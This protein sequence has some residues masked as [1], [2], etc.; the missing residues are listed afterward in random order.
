MS[1]EKTSRDAIEHTARDLRDT[2]VKNGKPDPG[3]DKAQK[4][5]TDAVKLQEMRRERGKGGKP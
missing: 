5:V 2:A 3:P 4:I 1:G